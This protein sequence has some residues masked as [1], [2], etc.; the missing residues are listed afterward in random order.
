MRLITIA[1]HTYPY[2]LSLKHTLADAGIE[3][4]LQNVNL[5]HPIVA[6]GVRVRIHEH[7]LAKALSIVEAMC[8][9]VP[10]SSSAIR[11]TA[12]TVLIPTDFSP[13]SDK[14][15]RLGLSIAHKHSCAALF[16]HSFITPSMLAPTP[17]SS[18]L[19]FDVTDNIV[20]DT[21]ADH[22]AEKR[23]HAFGRNLNA[24]IAAGEMPDTLY[25]MKVC[26]GV[27]EE[28]IA[29][30]AKAIAPMVIVMGTRDALKKEQELIGSVTAEVLDSVR[31]P[32]MSIP[33]NSPLTDTAS[34]RRILFFAVP[35]QQDILAIDTMQRILSL[36]GGTDVTIVNVPSRRDP[37]PSE[38]LLG[39]LVRYCTEHY[40]HLRFS[41]M[42]V[43]TGNIEESLAAFHNTY[44]LDL[45]VIPNRHRNI[46]SR[47]FNP[48][49]AHRL[50]FR[51]DLPMLA[52]P[53]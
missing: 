35:D 12:P 25:E 1:I 28:V 7:D 29:N 53:V 20:E 13:H 32:V 52:V 18:D 37:H 3:A 4:T 5:E 36:D 17:L 39:N 49:L 16:L 30:E 14:A 23:M 45:I 43:T 47:L 6:P 9:V 10:E 21:R 22:D 41:S 8:P 51:A 34:I 33:E 11:N 2:A 31:C 24:L 38:D 48:T 46:F 40:P 19:N 42:G 44:E 27:P 15:C 50:L 26:E